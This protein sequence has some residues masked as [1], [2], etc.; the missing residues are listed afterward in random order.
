MVEWVF[1]GDH[2]HPLVEPLKQYDIHW[3][4]QKVSCPP[5]VL[6]NERIRPSEKHLDD[7]VDIFLIIF[8]DV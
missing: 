1:I 8:I 6:F 4:S 2:A 5:C 7:G 3:G